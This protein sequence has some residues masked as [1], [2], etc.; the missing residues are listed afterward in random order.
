MNKPDAAKLFESELQQ[1]ENRWEK[2][3]DAS[4]GAAEPS[5]NRSGIDIKPLYSPKDRAD[6]NFFDDIGFPGEYPNTRGIYPSMHRGRS[7]TQ[8]QLIGWGVPEDYNQRLKEILAH[9]ATALSLIPCNSV[10]RGYDADEVPPELLGT[11]GVVV[12]S[13]EDMDICLADVPLDR[14]S[15]A[16]N[17]PSPFTLLALLLAVA[18]RRAIPLVQDH[19]HVEPVRLFVALRGQSHVFSP[20]AAGRAACADRSH[21]IRQ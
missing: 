10:Y 9:G 18:K 15:C 1:A 20:V 13:V 12:N 17:D 19:R 3:Y 11:C 21:R 6:E 5:V 7:W 8:R 14:I 16:L 2:A 4:A